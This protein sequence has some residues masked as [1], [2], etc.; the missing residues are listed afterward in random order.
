MIQKFT[1]RAARF[2]LS[3]LFIA[4]ITS[5]SFG[6]GVKT[7][8]TI[9]QRHTMSERHKKLAEMHTKM[10]TCLE[11]DKTPAACRQEMIDSC[12]SDFAGRC[13]MMGMGKR[14]GKGKGMM[15]GSYMDWMISPEPDIT[16]E[17]VKGQPT[18]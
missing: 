10:A 14:G 16:V 1:A 4:G 8:P 5:P 15:N 2:S 7:Q 3:I 17:P 18:K 13:P 9:T 11:S 12:S 6:Q